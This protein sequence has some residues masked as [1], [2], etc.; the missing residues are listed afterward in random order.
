M[1]GETANLVGEAIRLITITPKETFILV[2]LGFLGGILSGFIGSGG[3]FILTPGM[4]TLGVPGIVAVSSNLAHK[5]GKAMVGAKKHS[6]MGNVDIKLGSILTIFLLGGVQCAVFLQEY[7]FNSLGK[8]GSNLYISVVFVV[9]LSFLSVIMLRDV[10][11]SGQK[12]ESLKAEGLAKKLSKINIPPMIYFKLANVRV[13]LWFVALI[14]LATGW[15]AGTV[16]V[17]GFIGVPG[18]IYVLGVPTMVAAGTELFIAIFSGAFGSFQYALQGFVDIRLVLLL[19]IGSLLGL[20][21]GANATKMVSELQLKL[22]MVI[23]I[24]M[25]AVSRAFAIPKYLGDLHL[26]NLSAGVSSALN[27]AATIC[28]YGGAV[29]GVIMILYYIVRFKQGKSMAAQYVKRSE[30][31][32]RNS[33]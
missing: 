29:I 11:T 5:F 30:Q 15:L 6:K 16:G 21:I 33:A 12:H 23:I 26:V 28:L 13:S 20:L 25:S 4:M 32:E 14:G 2:G 22:V 7:I 8:A 18:M 3:A 9:L 19:Y 24:G 31:Q 1:A 10:L 27:I 17:G